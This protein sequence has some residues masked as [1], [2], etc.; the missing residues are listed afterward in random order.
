MKRISFLVPILAMLVS[1]ASCKKDKVEP[2]FVDDY[3]APLT[4]EKG[5]EHSGDFF[6]LDEGYY[7]DYSGYE[8]VIGEMKVS[9]PGINETEPIDESGNIH[10]YLVVNS[11]ESINL[12]SG[13]HSVYPVRESYFVDGYSYRYFEKT[14]EAINFRAFNAGY[15]ELTEV[16]DPLFIKIPLVVGDS[17][18]TQPSID[19]N[20]AL[21]SDNLG[22]STGEIDATIICKMYV[23]GKE[24]ISWDSQTVEPVRLDQIAEA[25]ISI[26]FNEEGVSGKIDMN[27]K[28]TNILYLLEN[29]GLIKQGLEMAMTINAS[30]SAEGEKM[31]I[32]MTVD[33]NGELN[34][35][36]HDVN[37]GTVKRSVKMSDNKGI[38]LNLENEKLSKAINNIMKS[39]LYSN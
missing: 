35:D 34:L 29:V 16:E 6:P 11:L 2:S 19:I 24:S 10:S 21:S 28:M 8:E 39:L 5:T 12:T 22:L 32:N 18:E 7:W 36:S 20:S 14:D 13:T 26:P 23:I 37:G 15:G 31:T 9:A 25:K 17:W 27:L 4:E 30:L 38:E 3:N 33:S 1:F